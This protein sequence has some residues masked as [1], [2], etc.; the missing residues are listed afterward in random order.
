MS[1]KKFVTSITVTVSLFF[2]AGCSPRMDIRGKILEPEKV[3]SIQIAQHTKEDVVRLL[4]SPTSVDSFDKNTWYYFSRK[5]ETVSFY[6]P[7]VLDSIAIKIDFDE[8]DIVK[9]VK[10]Q[11]ELAEEVAPIQ[12]ETPV[13]ESERSFLEQIFGSFGRFSRKES[14]KK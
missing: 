11:E 9:S 1:S 4:G 5:T 13:V 2:I 14:Q 10:I 7:K 8:K 3:K 6:D 12:R